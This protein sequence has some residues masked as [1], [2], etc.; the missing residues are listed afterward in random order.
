[1]IEL[2][3]EGVDTVFTTNGYA[4]GAALENLVLLGGGGG[5][6]NDLD[7]IILVDLF[8]GFAANHL[9]GGGGN[10][11][12]D[13]NWGADTL[14]GGTGS[15]GFQF[16]SPLETGVDAILDF[17]PADDTI[18]LNRNWFWSV[19]SADGPIDPA[20]FCT[21]P[22]AL[23]ADDRII[24]DPAT[25]RIF[26]DEDGLGGEAGIEFATVTAGTPLTAADFIAYGG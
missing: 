4:L 1:M 18:L 12:L 11:L 14:E 20:V 2:A 3:G 6:G 19:A 16:S 7:N 8:S 25:G 17:S 24:Y 5:I 9:A 21:G 22:A 13:G 23:E 15:D 10:D 26:F